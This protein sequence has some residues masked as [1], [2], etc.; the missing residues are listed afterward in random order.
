MWIDIAKL[1]S[2][3]PFHS[4]DFML[5]TH[6]EV[7]LCSSSPATHSIP[8]G[9]YQVTQHTH[10]FILAHSW[11]AFSRFFFLHSH[12]GGLSSG[13]YEEMQTVSRVYLNRELLNQS[14]LR[15]DGLALFL[16]IIPLTVAR[17]NLTRR[18]SSRQMLRVELGK[19]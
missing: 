9:L 11:C 4:M 6:T 1:S 14:G 3:A 13:F 19:G 7:L 2:S 10:C 18:L 12:V 15:G 17:M 5:C 8:S 16:L